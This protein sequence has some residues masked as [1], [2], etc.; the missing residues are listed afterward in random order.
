MFR[1]P[2]AL[3]DEELAGEFK[4]LAA[5]HKTVSAWNGTN[6]PPGHT[7][8]PADNLLTDG[9]LGPLLAAMLDRGAYFVTRDGTNPQKDVA[10]F[11]AFFQKS[12]RSRDPDVRWRVTI[13]AD[14][15]MQNL[16]RADVEFGTPT[17]NHRGNIH[18]RAAAPFLPAP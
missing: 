8:L 2:R 1:D 3:T 15:L 11:V 17:A 18:T 7:K 4:K 6:S 5:I 14:S 16:Y 12:R 10:A 9:K 13:A